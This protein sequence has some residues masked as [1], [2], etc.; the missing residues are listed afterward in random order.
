MSP[1]RRSPQPARPQ[2]EHGNR[3]DATEKRLRMAADRRQGGEE[4]DEPWASLQ[5]GRGERG[6]D[7]DDIGERI[8]QPEHAEARRRIDETGEHRRHGRSPHRPRQPTHGKRRHDEAEDGAERPSGV[9]EEQPRP[10]ERRE[11]CR[12]RIGEERRALPRPA[13]TPRHLPMTQQPQRLRIPRHELRHDVG[14]QRV[15]HP[16]PRDEIALPRPGIGHHVHRSEHAPRQKSGAAVE[17]GEKN[18]DDRGLAHRGHRSADAS[19]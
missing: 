12:L 11:K 6:K 10:G 5:R 19:W 18:K 8:E 3:D 4:N 14:Q 15:R 1:A 16:H 17:E 2:N 7:G 13:I 9:A